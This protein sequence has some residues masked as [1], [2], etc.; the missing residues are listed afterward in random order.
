M[1]R[2][3]LQTR[4]TSYGKQNDI[5]GLDSVS[6]GAQRM[7]E[8]MQDHT[9]EDGQNKHNARHHSG[10]ALAVAPVHQGNPADK[11]Q[12]GKVHMYIDSGKSAD[13]YGPLHYYSPSEKSIGF[14]SI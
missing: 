6:P 3:A 12:K 4:D 1:R 7:A 14:R 2:H 13:S 9:Q 11:Q 5:T 8:F 10:N